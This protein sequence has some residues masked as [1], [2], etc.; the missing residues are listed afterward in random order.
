VTSIHAWD[1]ATQLQRK[2]SGTG[3]CRWLDSQPD[4]LMPYNSAFFLNIH[5]GNTRERLTPPCGTP[6]I[7]CLYVTLHGTSKDISPLFQSVYHVNQYRLPQGTSITAQDFGTRRT[8][9][10]PSR[11]TSLPKSQTSRSLTELVPYLQLSVL[12]LELLIFIR[13]ALRKLVHFNAKFVNLFPDLSP[14]KTRTKG[15]PTE[16]YRTD[17]FNT[18]DLLLPTDGEWI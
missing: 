15:C 14:C 12:L 3:V 7:P 6:E 5:P 1:T 17:G 13:V 4:L 10:N 9:L 8:A 11:A 2:A 16:Q 18:T